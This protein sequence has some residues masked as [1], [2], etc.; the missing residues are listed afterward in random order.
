MS[1][2]LSVAEHFTQ[3]HEG[4]L[5]THGEVI[6]AAQ[7]VTSDSILEQILN[8]LE[9]KQS[10]I[11]VDCGS[12]FGFP[13]SYLSRKSNCLA[14]GLNIT[15]SQLNHSKKYHSDNCYFLKFDFNEIE[16]LPFNTTAITFMESFCYAENPSRLL[17]D[18]FSVLETG[19]RVLI[20]CFVK[21][22]KNWCREYAEAIKDFYKASF[23]SAAELSGW[24]FD[25][26][27]K[28]KS[29]ELLDIKDAQP[30]TAMFL[31]H[32]GNKE[33][34]LMWPKKNTFKPFIMV[35]EK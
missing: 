7:G 25:A 20:K 18:C 12:G 22:D 10:D 27:F 19:G 28:I 30:L 1:L 23:Y 17:A 15:D 5:A 29:F 33:Q 21:E 8:K 16:K 35:L 2:S 9:L 26:G 24:A 4:Y 3:Y 34:K 11:L 31:N 32:I 13:A 6:Q 14:I